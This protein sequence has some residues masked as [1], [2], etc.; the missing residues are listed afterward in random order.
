MRNSW[1]YLFGAALALEILAL[2]AGWQSVRYFSK[3]ALLLLL[4][5]HTYF[6]PL[7]Q[8]QN[9][10]LLIAALAFSWLGDVLLLF[11]SA[12]QLNFILGLLSFLLAHGCYMFLFIRLRRGSR[13]RPAA[14]PLFLTALILYTTALLYL[15]FPTLGALQLPVLVYA[16]ALSLMLLNA[17]ISFGRQKTRQAKWIIIG[18]A[19]FVLS[20]SLLAINKFYQPFPFAGSTVMLS[21]AAAQFLLV[22]GLTTEPHSEDKP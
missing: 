3:P 21:Y 14:Y 7:P 16:A 15:L 6:H 22:Y 4:L 13:S 17:Y 20:D 5:A 2:T 10:L 12:A 11:E 8:P 9:Q 1:F 19:C 18:A